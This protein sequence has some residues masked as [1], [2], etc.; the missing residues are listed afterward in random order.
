VS[1]A[2]ATQDV[3]DEIRRG[4][5]ALAAATAL[6]DLGLHADAVSRTYYGVFHHLRALLVARGV[7]PRSHAGAIHLFNREFVN[8]GLFPA[9]CNRLLAGLQRAR[10]L[11]DYSAAVT[12]AETDAR[13]DL[14]A[15]RAFCAEVRAWLARERLLPQDT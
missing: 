5:D 6:L 3:L 2:P 15:A 10:E 11:A 9:T 4:E 7:E 1:T 13:T 14:A 12:F 8:T